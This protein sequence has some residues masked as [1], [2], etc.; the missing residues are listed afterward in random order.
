M[1]THS[2]N[3]TNTYISVAED[4]PVSKAEIP[5]QKGE[6]KSIANMQFDM[7]YENPYKYTSDEILFDI[8]AKRKGIAKA[9]LK[10]ERE[11]FY[12]KGQACLRASP[13]AKRYGWGIHHDDKCRVA[14]YAIESKEYKHLS[15]DKA[16][17]QTKAMRSSK[18]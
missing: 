17:V 3:Y 6:E 18:K 15:S 4:C 14:I 8:H 13:L 7:V 12:S 10:A 2:T 5:P 16:L 9:D 1:K 11:A